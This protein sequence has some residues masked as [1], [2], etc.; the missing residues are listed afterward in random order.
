MK[1]LLYGNQVSNDS[2]DLIMGGLTVTL[3]TSVVN[4]DKSEQINRVVKNLEVNIA[5]TSVTNREQMLNEGNPDVLVET[6]VWGESMW[7]GAKWANSTDLLEA[8][9]AVSCNGSF[10]VIGKRGKLSKTEKH[11]LRDAMILNTH[12][13]EGR[14]IFVS[15]DIKA[16]GRT[17]T[18]TRTSLEEL[19]DT[20]IMTSLEF[21]GYCE[22]LNS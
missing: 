13:R 2:S 16:I 19:C 6:A 9:L 11:Q 21:I 1:H 18:K 7:G 14:D 8:I 12:V 20:K 15:D 5:I 22:S 4:K 3:D 17:G 10:P